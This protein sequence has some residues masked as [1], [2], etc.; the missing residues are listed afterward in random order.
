MLLGSVSLGLKSDTYIHGTA[1]QNNPN[2]QFSRG[3]DAQYVP[4]FVKLAGMYELPYGVS[5]GV[6]GQYYQGWPDTNTVL[7]TPGT[8]RL[9]QVNQ[10]IVVE[11]RG[12]TTLADV[13]MFDVNVRKSFTR[14]HVTATPRVDIFNLFNAAAITQR[15]TQFGPA[16]GNAIEALGAR[17]IKFGFDLSF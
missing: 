9:T 15:I 8:V 4:V 17:L 1:D 13:T 6:S 11:P 10:S 2:F 7:V 3:S 16:Y 14:G 12:T 5:A